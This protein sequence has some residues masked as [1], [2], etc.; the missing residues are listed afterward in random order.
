MAF[1][2]FSKKELPF[3]IK[4]KGVIIIIL[5]YLFF[6]TISCGPDFSKFKNQPA[7]VP[8][9]LIVTVK[10]QAFNEGLRKT[11]IMNQVSG[12]LLQLPSSNPPNRYSEVLWENIA[13]PDE[14]ESY[15]LL[16]LSLPPGSNMEQV[17]SQLLQKPEVEAVDYNWIHR[18][19]SRGDLALLPAENENT[20]KPATE[21]PSADESKLKLTPITKFDEDFTNL[22]LYFPK[23]PYFESRQ[24]FYMYLTGVT[25]TWYAIYHGGGE[26]EKPVK[27]D[28]YGVIV[29]GAKSDNIDYFNQKPVN[30]AVI[31]NGFELTHPDMQG[32]WTVNEY[33]TASCSYD[34]DTNVVKDFKDCHN[35][36]DN[37]LNGYPGDI[38]G[39]NV[40]TSSPMGVFPEPHPNIPR[41]EHGTHVAG[42]IAAKHNNGIGIAGVCISCQVLPINASQASPNASGQWEAILPDN[43]ILKGLRYIQNYRYKDIDIVNLSIGMYRFS[44]AYI[45]G[46]E[47]VARERL[48]V[49]A[50]SNEDSDRLSYPAA[51][52]SV[53]SVGA[54][55]GIGETPAGQ[56]AAK[57]VKMKGS[58][59]SHI[60]EYEFN[61]DYYS[62]KAFFS[63][64]GNHIDILAP[65]VSIYS[66][67]TLKDSLE[68]ETKKYAYA[69]GTSQASPFVAGIAALILPVLR[70]SETDATYLYGQPGYAVNLMYRLIRTANGNVILHG[71]NEPY[72]SSKSYSPGQ[73]ADGE[74][75]LGAG[76]I[77]AGHALHPYTE[78]ARKVAREEPVF[79]NMNGCFGLGL[80]LGDDEPK[81]NS[82]LLL[83]IYS[84]LII[85]TIW[86]LKIKINEKS[87]S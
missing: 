76:L 44:R 15:T 17:K 43:M 19:Q 84:L 7:Y 39:Y 47:R 50:A 69:N 58:L 68:A 55:G 13:D 66:T 61:H 24:L 9:E 80:D 38:L 30:V 85:L 74:Q 14:N 3:A 65:G 2:V 32:K 77:N 29:R 26:L 52:P 71:H 10:A 4:V 28:D 27:E 6:V 87:V 83:L 35:Y 59:H 82:G 33:E 16:R 37:D 75:Y 70:N 40:D 81:G 51:V 64:F 1:L 79:K 56:V 46:I 31:D 73:L 21:N 63:N 72:Q 25:K 53:M 22:P 23:D 67:I 62:Q 41:R 8:G 34:T 18:I 54:I 12:Q 20:N 42:I 5:V 45:I 60:S 48:V 36:Q 49:A 11:G 57:T 86:V 78:A